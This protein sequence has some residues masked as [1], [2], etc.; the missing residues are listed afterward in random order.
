MLRRP[1]LRAVL[2]TGAAAALL[3]GGINLASYAT[4]HHGSGA[5]AC[6]RPRSSSSTSACRTSL[7][8][9]RFPAVH[10]QDPDRQLR[11]EHERCSD[12]ATDD[13]VTATRAS[14]QTRGPGEGLDVTRRNRG[15]SGSTRPPART[16]TRR[17]A[18]AS[19]S[20]ATPT[21]RFTSTGRRSCRLRLQRRRP[22]RSSRAGLHVTP[23]KV[24]GRSGKRFIPALPKSDLQRLAAPCAEDRERCA[25]LGGW[26]GLRPA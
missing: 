8:R 5:G 26:S 13:S 22:Y 12:T 11:R 7:Q 16:S 18:S 23:V 19:A 17:A 6:P 9:W 25:A 4:T 14:P 2:A 15:S 24:D 21:R 1:P 20:S 3:V 10:G